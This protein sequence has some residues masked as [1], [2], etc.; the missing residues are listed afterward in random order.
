MNTFEAISQIR[1]QTLSRSEALKYLI[2]NLGLSASYANEIVTVVFSG[3]SA[4]DDSPATSVS[5]E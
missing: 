2:E 1:R 5:G 3:E 4:N